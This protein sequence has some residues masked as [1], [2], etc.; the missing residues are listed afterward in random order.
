MHMLRTAKRLGYR[1]EQCLTDTCVFGMMDSR[2]QAEVRM[3]LL[4]HVD[5]VMVNGLTSGIFELSAHLN[6]SLKT[7]ILGELTTHY[8]G[9]TFLRHWE[10][11][12]CSSTRCH[13]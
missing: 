10:R 1:I 9:I 5:D 12:L 3:V 4:Y 13:A 11:G 6:E 7:N 8:R 2:G